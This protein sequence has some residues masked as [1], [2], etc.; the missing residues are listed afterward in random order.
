[1]IDRLAFF[2]ISAFFHVLGLIPR[3]GS[4]KLGQ[5]FGLLAFGLDRKHRGITLE[6][7]RRAYGAE[8]TSFEIKRLA[9]EV[10]RNL[11]QIV[12]EIG[13]SLRLDPCLRRRFFRIEGRPHLEEARARGRGVLILTAHF[14]NWELLTVAADM[15]GHSLHIVYRPLDFRPLDRFFVR[16]RTRYGA[17]LISKKRS[18][19]RILQALQ[20]R[21]LIGLLMDQDVF[22]REGVF[23]DFFGRRACTNKGMALVALKTGAPVVPIFLIR[24][25]DGFVVK[26]LPPVPLLRTGDKRK[27]VES[28]TGQYNRVIESMVRRYPDQWF[29]VHQR[30]KEKPYMPWPREKKITD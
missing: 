9:K 15:I 20:R 21:Q 5:A 1:M 8:K 2:F 10:F 23:A 24:E 28:N 12:F 17:G 19:R 26:I 7:L 27:D 25:P 16:L 6:N 29:W 13:W 22:R 3:S 30:W 11:G 14:G 4:R 18:M